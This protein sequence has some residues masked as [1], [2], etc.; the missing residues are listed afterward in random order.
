MEKVLIH[1]KQK[2]CEPEKGKLGLFFSVSGVF[3]CICRFLLFFFTIVFPP[4]SR[5]SSILNC[6]TKKNVH[7]QKI[8]GN[9]KRKNA[10]KTNH[11]KKCKNKAKRKPYEKHETKGSNLVRVF[12]ALFVKRCFW[13]LLV[14][15]RITCEIVM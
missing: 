7:H 8:I 11:K 2:K 10:G 4:I 12:S 3:L 6:F 15:Q 13:L 9:R 14:H 1:Q 5:C